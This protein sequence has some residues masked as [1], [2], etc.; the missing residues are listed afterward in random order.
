MKKLFHKHVTQRV[1]RYHRHFTKY[2]YERDTIFATL[3]IFIFMIVLGLIPINFYFLNPL[4]LALKDFDFN[5]I[6]YSKLGK[7]AD[8][9]RDSRILII[10]IGDLDRQGLSELIDKTATYGPKVIGLDVTFAGHTNQSLWDEEQFLNNTIAEYQKS[11]QHS[12][13]ML[14]SLQKA[15]QP[16]ADSIAKY[17]GDIFIAQTQITDAED[18]IARLK[19]LQDSAN[20]KDSMLRQTFL[21]TKNLVVVSA[22]DWEKSKTPQFEDQGFFGNDIEKQGY[23]NVIGESKDERRS[24]RYYST[25]EKEKKKLYVSFGAT[26]V[27]EFDA[28]AY[29]KVMARKKKQEIL[30][31]SRHTNQYHVRQAQEVLTDALDS[32]WYK[33]KIVLLGYV[34]EDPNNLTDK[35]YTPMNP[36]FAGKSTPDMN[37][38]II[39][40]NYI[41]MVLDD[42]YIKTLPSWV[43][44]LVAVLI[45]WLHMSFFIRYYLESHIWFHLVAKIAQLLSAIFFVYL[46][47][48]LYDRYNIKLDMKYTLITIV[49]AVDIIYFYEAFAVWMHKKFHYHTVFHQKHH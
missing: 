11:I 31:Y 6:T 9:E 33:G 3:W 19:V 38:I 17:Q 7:S 29:D 46:G 28:K 37:G 35:F 24:I 26:L 15:S 41:S 16:V 27:K 18:E 4:K 10:N 42:D 43:N 22:L 32:S 1:K 36:K 8:K 23:A 49:L 47:M 14:Q 44:W 40:A 34:S 39:H 20:V 13:S 5:D 21:R 2:L 30:N 48:L 12:D 45:G 25:Y